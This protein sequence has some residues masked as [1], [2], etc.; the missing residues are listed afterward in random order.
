VA[1]IK[2]Q[3][4]QVNCRIKVQLPLQIAQTS[5]LADVIAAPIAKRREGV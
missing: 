4:Q 5:S 3:R 2:P 1:R